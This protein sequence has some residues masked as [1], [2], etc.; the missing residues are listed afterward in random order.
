MT[1]AEKRYPVRRLIGILILIVSLCLLL[2][3]LWPFQD[4]IRTLPVFPE[5]MSVPGS[6]SLI[7]SLFSGLFPL[8]VFAPVPAWAQVRGKGPE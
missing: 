2:W 1:P 4:A 5:N 3:G 8:W 6:S 7:P